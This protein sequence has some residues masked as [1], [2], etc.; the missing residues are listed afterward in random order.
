MDRLD[1]PLMAAQM[2]SHM[3]IGDRK[4]EFYAMGSCF[5]SAVN[6]PK[7]KVMASTVIIPCS[8]LI[9]DSEE[10]LL[11]VYVKPSERES[12]SYMYVVQ[13]GDEPEIDDWGASEYGGGEMEEY[14]FRHPGTSYDSDDE[15]IRG[16]NDIFSPINT[17]AGQ[18]LYALAF[19]RGSQ[20]DDEVAT[21]K[22]AVLRAAYKLQLS[23]RVDD[24]RLALNLDC[25]EYKPPPA[26][27]TTDSGLPTLRRVERF[28]SCT[29]MGGRNRGMFGMDSDASDS[30]EDDD[31]S[32]DE[33]VQPRDGGSFDSDTRISLIYRATVGDFFSGRLL[34]YRVPLVSVVGARL[35][36]PHDGDED[37][38]DDADA[39]VDAALVLELDTPPPADAFAARKVCSS[40]HKENRFA[41]VDDWTPYKVASRASRVYIYG[42]LDELRQLAAHLATISAQF[43]GLV[44][45]PP[46]KNKKSGAS[47]HTACNTLAAPVSLRYDAAPSFGT[48]VP[49]SSAMDESSSSGTDGSGVPSLQSLS[50]SCA[51]KVGV[52]KAA[53]QDKGFPPAAV[54][55]IAVAEAEAKAARKKTKLGVDEVHALLVQRGLVTAD[56]AE[57]VNPC[58][59]KGILLGHVTIA[60]DATLETPLHTGECVCCSSELVCTIGDALWQTTYAGCDYEDGGENGAVQCEDCCGNYIT[61]LCTNEPHFDSGKF[62]NH[63][64]ACPDFGECIFDYRNQHCHDC[65]S[66]YFAGM[67]GFA[68]P[69]CGGGDGHR[70]KAVPL[71]DLPPPDPS[72]WDGILP[73]IDE[74]LERMWP[75]LDPMQKVMLVSAGC[76][77]ASVSGADTGVDGAMRAAMA[78][79]MGSGSAGGEDIDSRG[80]AMM[81]MMMQLMG[82]G[83]TDREDDDD[84]EYD[85]ESDD[86]SDRI[87]EEDEYSGHDPAAA[88]EA[89]PPKNATVAKYRELLRSFEQTDL[90]MMFFETPADED[91][92]TPEM[93]TTES[94]LG[95]HHLLLPKEI[96]AIARGYARRASQMSHSHMGGGTSLGNA[97]WARFMR[98]A[99]AAAVRALSSDWRS[100]LGHLLGV[101]MIGIND[102]TWL[103]DQEEY[104]DWDTFAD[105]F[106]T[107][108]AT[109]QAVLAQSDGVLGL[110]PP[111]GKPGGYRADLLKLL[112]DWE[113]DVNETLTSYDEF[114]EDGV[115]ARLKATKPS[116][117][118]KGQGIARPVTANA[119]IHATSGPGPT[120]LSAAT[121]TSQEVTATVS[122]PRKTRGRT[123][124]R[125]KHSSSYQPTAV[126][127]Y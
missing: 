1:N 44:A 113:N 120:T 30:D 49:V 26:D 88:I 102:D 89:Q 122:Q 6:V 80:M 118:P 63:C 86:D 114:A 67:S 110:A 109:W 51:A 13:G 83:G 2:M 41:T 121:A 115:P 104:C 85:D 36:V 27:P 48:R 82:G 43:A 12:E 74:T 32:L 39:K 123:A 10:D 65:G 77:P 81:A 7:T 19:A 8:N 96:A 23:V 119:N 78:T 66:H 28:D 99:L 71:K 94:L 126:Y 76:A 17:K 62:H 53:L 33:I 68:C 57:R 34:R 112:S 98:P 4:L 14:D 125:T 9:E 87:Q 3:A 90:T 29:G 116:K 64:T 95:K 11:D 24:K 93:V 97:M 55:A 61:A 58:L 91:A 20:P 16:D 38:G 5:E 18:K 69:D 92:D 50:A 79:L 47:P 101:L 60:E 70:A 84:G 40:L 15:D 105:Y 73:G 111:R 37:D 75:G 72:T 21:P 52:T 108:T 25:F 42:A 54:S 117:R 22:H 103:Q 56:E 127:D 46:K 100:A 35:V 45:P 124:K 107:L 59:K 106:S 31:P